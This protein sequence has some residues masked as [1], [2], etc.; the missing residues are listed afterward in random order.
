M[1]SGDWQLMS[2]SRQYPLSPLIQLS[3]S[4]PQSPQSRHF[5]RGRHGSSICRF[6]SKC[7]PQI[8]R[9][10]I[11]F[12]VSSKSEHRL[13]DCPSWCGRDL[14]TEQNVETDKPGRLSVWRSIGSSA[15]AMDEQTRLIGW[16]V[17]WSVEECKIGSCLYLHR[18]IRYG[19]FDLHFDIDSSIL[20]S[21]SSSGSGFGSRSQLYP[22]TG[23]SSSPS[24]SSWSDPYGSPFCLKSF[25]LQSI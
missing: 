17:D 20:S 7:N 14:I 22:H 19:S 23:A 25:P 11:G 10:D 21:S 13:Q 9:Y 8:V 5:R 6:E 16:W 4:H 2:L 12:F 3:P 18:G 24:S 1:K 15:E